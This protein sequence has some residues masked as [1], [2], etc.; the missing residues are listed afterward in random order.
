VHDC[1]TPSPKHSASAGQ[2][3]PSHGGAPDSLLLD[4]ADVV[5]LVDDDSPA[6]ELDATSLVLSLLDVVVVA[7][8]LVDAVVVPAVLAV[9]VSAKQP[10]PGQSG[11]SSPLQ[12]STSASTS[13]LRRMGRWYRTHHGVQ[14]LS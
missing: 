2:S 1:Q 3:A 12:A 8:V 5:A 7:V 10:R 9:P 13:T 11:S 4:S 6:L 14:S